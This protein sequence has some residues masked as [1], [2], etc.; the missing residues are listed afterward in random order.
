MSV[1]QACNNNASQAKGV[2]NHEKTKAADLHF[3]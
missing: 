2:G 1:L 3:A